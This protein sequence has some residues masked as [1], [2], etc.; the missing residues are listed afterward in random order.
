MLVG[1]LFYRSFLPFVRGCVSLEDLLNACPNGGIVCRFG[2]DRGEHRF[3]CVLSIR[4]ADIRAPCLAVSDNEVFP[5]R[6]D[7]IYTKEIP[8][9]V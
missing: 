9:P 2:R 4:S 8:P 7:G 6:Q 5:I 1:L 3:L